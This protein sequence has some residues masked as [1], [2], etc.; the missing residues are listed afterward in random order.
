M[1]PYLI[2]LIVMAVL[3]VVFFFIIIFRGNPRREVRYIDNEFH[4]LST[5]REL[6]RRLAG[7]ESRAG[8]QFVPYISNIEEGIGMKRGRDRS[9][10]RASRGRQQ[11]QVV[12]DLR[13]T[14]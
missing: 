5:N 6:D 4:A 13:P 10:R 8:Q 1:S 14:M 12:G 3:F 7:A 11:V 9:G 2:A